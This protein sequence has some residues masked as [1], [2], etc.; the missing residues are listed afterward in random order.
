[1]A[2]LSSTGIIRPRDAPIDLK[3]GIIRRGG[4]GGRWHRQLCAPPAI[5]A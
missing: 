3:R 1:M 5:A 2:T 4:S